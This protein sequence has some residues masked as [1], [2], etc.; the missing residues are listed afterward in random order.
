MKE[1]YEDVIIDETLRSLIELSF[2]KFKLYCSAVMD[3]RRREVL[4]ERRIIDTTTWPMDED[5]KKE[6]VKIEAISRDSPDKLDLMNPF[7]AFHLET[8][9]NPETNSSVMTTES[10]VTKI[11]TL[12]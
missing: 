12:H 3:L 7:D 11:V 2:A 9:T 8:V 6:E 10:G 5:E 4:A 1:I